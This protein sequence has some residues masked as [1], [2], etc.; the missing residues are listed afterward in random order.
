MPAVGGDEH[1]V[2]LPELE[3]GGRGG[4]DVA[5]AGAVLHHA[6]GSEPVDERSVARLDVVDAVG[7]YEGGG[8]R[9]LHGK[10]RDR[11]KA[12]AEAGGPSVRAC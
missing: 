10:H 5:H 4:A 2:V 11:D 12:L 3:E 6:E 1:V 9:H 7:G 8:T